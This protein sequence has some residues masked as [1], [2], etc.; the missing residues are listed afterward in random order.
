MELRVIGKQ[1]PNTTALVEYFKT[2]AVEE[3]R[4]YGQIEQDTKLN[5]RPG[6]PDYAHCLSAR[7]ALESENI[8]I[9]A[10]SGLGLRRLNDSERV[11]GTR[12]VIRRNSKA[13]KRALNNLARVNYSNLSAED[14]VKHTTSAVVLHV[15]MSAGR[16]K[17]IE[18]LAS[19]V[20]TKKMDYSAAIEYFKKSQ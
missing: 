6:Y 2:W 4:D 17:S 14:Q 7:K 19:A 16:G 5:V 3:E 9:G 20:E 1:H 13:A 12:S 18:K 10:V 11:K 15:Q 8:Y